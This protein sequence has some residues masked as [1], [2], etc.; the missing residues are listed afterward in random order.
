MKI[1]N[2][3]CIGNF[4]FDS[5]VKVIFID[6]EGRKGKCWFNSFGVDCFNGIVT[7][8]AFIQLA[9]KWQRVLSVECV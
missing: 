2:V 4:K 3:E 8:V 1:C 5:K 7:R 9:E 6:K